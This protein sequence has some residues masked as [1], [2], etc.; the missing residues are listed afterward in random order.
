MGATLIQPDVVGQTN[1]LLNAL[2][3]TLTDFGWHAYTEAFEG[4]WSKFNVFA[5]ALTLMV[6]TAGLPHVIVRFY[7]VKNVCLPECF[8]GF[9]VYID[10]LLV[11]T[12]LPFSRYYMIHTLNGSSSESL[13]SWF[14]SWENRLILW[15]DDGDGIV[16]YSGITRM[17]FFAQVN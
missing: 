7:T 12:F 6:G 9:V 14:H 3:G 15:L 1:F 11:G 17:K 10:S 2:D 5:T 8:L 16:H 13:P 4:K